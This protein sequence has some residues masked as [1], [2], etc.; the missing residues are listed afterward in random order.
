M[1]L[2][3]QENNSEGGLKK[4]DATISRVARRRHDLANVQQSTEANTKPEVS[5]KVWE[6]VS[7][8]QH[9]SSVTPSNSS[10]TSQQQ[11]KGGFFSTLFGRT[12]SSSQT[13]QQTCVCLNMRGYSFLLNNNRLEARTCLTTML[14]M[15]QQ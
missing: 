1:Y 15:Q 10:A 5:K 2:V 7:S 12:P 14:V 9:S 11:K 13:A 4:K 6:S 3:E 8:E